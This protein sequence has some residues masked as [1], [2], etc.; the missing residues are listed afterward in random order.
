[1][2][3]SAM[4]FGLPLDSS[5]SLLAAPPIERT[6]QTELDEGEAAKVQAARGGDEAAFRILVERYR[7]RVYA[8]ALRIC[9][10]PHAAEEIAQ[11]TF[12]R[13]WRALPVFRGDSRFSTWL[14]RIA[15]RRALDEK[16]AID[17]RR[18][19]EVPGESETHTI[20]DS[21][22]PVSGD[23]SLR[24]KLER[25][26]AALPESQRIALTLFYGADQ[27]IEEIGRIL[28]GPQGTV[29]THLS[30]G[31]AELRVLWDREQPASCAS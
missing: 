12:V 6:R 25:L 19:R 4:A 31:R 17:R 26:V 10:D 18:G 22:A 15:F 11:D 24:R 5:R 21:P 16:A 27:S 7:D 8:L 14:Y 13:A 23:F 30:R 28:D 9:K 2:I 29:K 3:M 20:E 1:M